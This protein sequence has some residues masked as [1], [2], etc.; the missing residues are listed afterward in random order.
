M[1]TTFL[2][3]SGLVL[4]SCLSFSPMEAE[5]V[6]LKHP[7]LKNIK[8]GIIPGRYI[9]EFKKGSSSPSTFMAQSVH[10]TLSKTVKVK[11]KFN[12]KLFN[13]ASIDV[14][15][16]GTEALKH[17]LEL[18][19]VKAVYPVEEYH[20]ADHRS[21]AAPLEKRDSTVPTRIPQTL[22]QVDR[23]RSELGYKGKDVFIGIIDSGIDYMHPALGGGFGKG[24]KVAAGY[25]L[26]GDYLAPDGSYLPDN[27]PYM[28]CT[29][30]YKPIYA[31]HCT[32]IA[33]IIAGNSKEDDFYGVAP[34][35]TSGVWRVF[36]CLNNAESDI[37]IKA[38]LMAYDAGVDIISM[39]I[40][41]KFGFVTESPITEVVKKVVAGGVHFVNAAG[42]NGAYDLFNVG[43]PAYNT[44]ALSVGA[45][46]VGENRIGFINLTS[47]VNLRFPMF[48]T[49]AKFPKEGEL[50]LGDKGIHKS[51]PGCELED[52][53]D[54]VKG[55]IVITA[56]GG[57]K[58]SRRAS[59]AA[60]KGAIGLLVYGQSLDVTTADNDGT[61]IP[62]VFLKYLN[63]SD[64]VELLKAGK[65]MTIAFSTNEPSIAE[66]S[67]AGPNAGIELVPRI[68]AIGDNVN[69]TV[70]VSFGSYSLF[71]GT[72]MAT[73][74]VAGSIALYLN[75]VGKKKQSVEYVNEV[76]QNYARPY[77]AEAYPM[78]DNPIRQSAGMIQVYD[79]ITQ[80][81]HVS[82]SQI[83]FND[84]ASN[85]YRTQTI[86]ITNGGK[87]IVQFDVV[88]DPG[89]SLSLDVTRDDDISPLRHQEV[90]APAKLTFS[91]QT[92]KISPGNSQEIKITV[93]PPTGDKK[94]HIF[95]GG[96]I[97]LVSK[98]Q[99][100]NV[101][102]RVPYIGVNNDMRKVP[103][104]KYY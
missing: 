71:S 98:Q 75:A 76:L 67:S 20:L 104:F 74:F 56:F 94:N 59:I 80:G 13:A 3:L 100:N 48:G 99:K 50:V 89:V 7:K 14:G 54:S 66:F 83:S 102:V 101:D 36:T 91:K 62:T 69:S 96:F 42:N 70:P 82:P 63:G 40:I 30:K 39:S 23:V 44:Q 64:I 19:D 35:A 34:E 41:K 18:S 17:I 26:V 25:D 52:V 38:I 8:S 53:P 33:G 87:E 24:Y 85:A 12:H 92:M 77:T 103:D 61:E 68:S 84:T 5:A 60:Q 97:R 31:N 15:H 4:W 32:H 90:N 93:T 49:V 27:D 1:K 37:I 55:K 10:N 81:V 21:K 46:T 95:Y 78:I 86:K 2:S 16:S 43:D 65:K 72:S 11:N 58:N 28:N 29:G 88:N 6:N 57:C 9:V 79:A 45:M 47:D 22:A 73:P 51:S